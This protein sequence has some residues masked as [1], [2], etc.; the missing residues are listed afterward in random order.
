MPEHTG[1]GEC[2]EAGD[3][4]DDIQIAESRAARFQGLLEGYEADGPDG[5]VPGASRPVVT[6]HKDQ[7]LVRKHPRYAIVTRSERWGYFINL[8]DDIA[9]VKEVA[10]A[11]LEEGWLP[12]CYF[13]LDLLVGEEPLPGE[14]DKVLF[15]DQG[16]MFVVC[17]HD[18]LIEGEVAYTYD[19]DPKPETSQFEAM[20]RGVTPEEITVIEPATPDERNPVRY[21]LAQLVTIAVFNSTPEAP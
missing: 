10:V 6:T 15:E 9:G 20:Y 11:N 21:L 7:Q 19:I 13:D 1:A 8:A 4:P 12:V 3:L 2:V 5:S 18:D 16:E 17:E 14:G